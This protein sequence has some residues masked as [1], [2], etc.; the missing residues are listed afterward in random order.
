MELTRKLPYSKYS[1][2]VLILGK[3][4]KNVHVIP[5]FEKTHHEDEEYRNSLSLRLCSVFCTYCMYST[6]CTTGTSAVPRSCMLHASIIRQ[7]WCQCTGTVGMWWIIYYRMFDT[8]KS[9]G[10]HTLSFTKIRSKFITQIE[11]SIITMAQWT[12]WRSIT[13]TEFNRPAVGPTL[14]QS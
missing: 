1:R 6:T 2:M 8:V 11:R 9:A 10:T 12:W 7:H 14:L 13:T 4:L 3:N 5:K